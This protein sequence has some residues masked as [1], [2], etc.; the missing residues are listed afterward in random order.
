M[1]EDALAEDMTAITR[2]LEAAGLTTV[3]LSDFF[4]HRYLVIRED[5]RVVAV[6]GL[7]VHGTYGLLR[8]VAVDPAYRNRGLARQLVEQQLWIAGRSGLHRVYLLTTSA[9]AYFRQLGFVAV[10]RD[11]APA[12]IRASK[13]FAAVCPSSAALLAKDPLVSRSTPPVAAR[14]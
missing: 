8:S 9:A 2:L 5:E 10:A 3:G 4:P 13:E 14:R 1:A 7:E 11:D 6:A 12:A